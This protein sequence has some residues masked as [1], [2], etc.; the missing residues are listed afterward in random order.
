MYHGDCGRWRKLRLNFQR[1]SER[2]KQ[3]DTENTIRTKHLVF[4]FTDSI[5]VC[6]ATFVNQIRGIPR[7]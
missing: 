1:E 3:T 5:H 2:R 4:W 6:V 7:I